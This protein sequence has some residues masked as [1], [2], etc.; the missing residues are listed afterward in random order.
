MIPVNEPVIPKQAKKYVLDCLDTAWVSS[1]GTY[2]SRFEQ[3]FASYIGMKYAS[4]VSN[5]TAALHIALLMLNI[6]K[7]DEVIVPDLTIISCAFA[8]M[9]VGAKPVPVDVE[10]ETGNL[11]PKKIEKAI[12]KSTKAIMVV[13]LYGHAARMKEIM[14]IAKKH[15]LKIIE[16]AA[17]AH[18]GEYRGKKLG[19]FGDVSCFSFYGNKIVTCGEG[20]MVLTNN[21]Q[22]YEQCILLKDLAHK[23]GRRFFHEEIGYNYRLTNMQAALGLGTLEQIE[24]SIKRKRSMATLYNKLLSDISFLK[25]PT[26]SEYTKSVYWMYNIELSKDA[27]ISRDQFMQKLH[28]L[29]VDTRTYFYPLHAQPVLKKYRIQKHAFPVSMRLSTRGLYLPSGLAIT[30]A[31]IRTVS[32]VIHSIFK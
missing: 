10:A 2:V 28:E 27:P 5:G 18:G 9:Y 1:A 23:K 13:H 14:R 32:K 20:G 4:T 12:T 21:D 26:E 16:D 15:S 31:Q 11:D 24:K 25:L 30:D 6:G 7:G 22:L 3:K 19:S 8:V 17:E 29:G